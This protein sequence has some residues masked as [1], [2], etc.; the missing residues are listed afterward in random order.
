MSVLLQASKLTKRFPGVLALD[1]VSLSVDKGELVAVI[2]ENGAGKST[3]MKVLAGIYAPDAGAIEFDGRKGALKGVLEAQSVGIA[4]IH[5]ELNLA[6]NL[7]VAG[8]VFLGREAQKRGFIRKQ[9]MREKTQVI[10]KRLGATFAADAPV[11]SLSLGQKQMVEIAKAL[12]LDAKL[13]IMDEPTSSLSARETQ[14]LFEVM[15]ALRGQGMSILY[16][17]HRLG[18]VKHLADRV[19]ALRDGRNAGELAKSEIEHDAMVRLMVGRDMSKVFAHQ[20]NAK[21]WVVLDVHGLRTQAHPKEVIGFDLHRGEIVGLA[22]LVGSGRTELLRAL[23]GIEPPIA[24]NVIVN[25]VP[26]QAQHPRQAI[27]AGLALVPEDRK[28]L[29]IFLPESVSWNVSL[30]SVAR[31]ARGGAILNRAAERKHAEQ[32][33]DKLRIKT[34]TLDTEVGTLSGGNQ[35]KVA[36]AKWLAMQPKVL[37]LD[38]PTRGIDVGAKREIYQLMEALAADGMAILFVSSEM[39]EVLAMSDRVL[40]MHEGGL[41][42]E[43]KREELSEEAV[44]R[45]AT[46]R[47][48]LKTPMTNDPA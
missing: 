13:L 27:D 1:D 31:D 38:E 25:G 10:L 20:P 44:M 6:D 26:L 24:G 37:L 30:P 2:G 42:G 21:T 45:L 3:L 14:T 33:R 7:D 18:E 5:Q 41:A 17:S 12:S 36:L 39:E 19:V 4:L 23:F 16:I 8:N 15:L 48:K 28:A 47:A 40:V 32:S 11:E 46:G 35:Q 22:G 43:L 34:A 29:G 9:E